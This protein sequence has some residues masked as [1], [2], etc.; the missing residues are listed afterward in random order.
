MNSVGVINKAHDDVDNSLYIFIS[1]SKEGFVL[2]RENINILCGTIRDHLSPVLSK[3][4][5]S[6]PFSEKIFFHRNR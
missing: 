6:R 5:S 1:K 4:D 3:I 2:P